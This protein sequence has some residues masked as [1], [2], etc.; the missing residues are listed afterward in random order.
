[1]NFAYMADNVVDRVFMV[2]FR[3][4][5]GAFCTFASRIGFAFVT[6]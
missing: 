2:N 1:M 5:L 3:T 4:A 6:S